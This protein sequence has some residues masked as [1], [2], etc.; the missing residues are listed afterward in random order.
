LGIDDHQLPFP[1]QVERGAEFV[2]RNIGSRQVEQRAVAACISVTY[3][4]YENA[5]LDAGPGVDLA[6]RSQQGLLVGRTII[7]AVALRGQ[8]D[9]VVPGEP[10]VERGL[11]QPLCLAVELPAVFLGAADTADDQQVMLQ[12]QG[13]LRGERQQAGGEDSFH[14]RLRQRR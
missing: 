13:S 8:H 2:G 5:V 3:Q 12:R 9:D 6:N 14:I 10:G 11:P 4:D 7:R 1:E